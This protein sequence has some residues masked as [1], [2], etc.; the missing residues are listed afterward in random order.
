MTTTDTS[1][2]DLADAIASLGTMMSGQFSSFEQKFEQKLDATEQRLS[3]Q[4]SELQTELTIF[5]RETNEFR[6]ETNE[7]L[8]NL[9]NEAAAVRNDIKEI[10]DR[11]VSIEKRLQH[12]SPEQY[13]QLRR[14]L[15]EL[16]VWACQVSAY[17]GIALPKLRR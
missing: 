9:S 11:L 5:K 14:E 8:D 17:T 10:Y 12:A 2:E 15:D 4:I 7:R 16:K 13:S 3:Q 6:R 1:I